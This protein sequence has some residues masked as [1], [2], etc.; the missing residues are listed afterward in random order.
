MRKDVDYPLRKEMV[1][2]AKKNLEKAHKNNPNY[3][4]YPQDI[5]CELNRT[6]NN[7]YTFDE[8]G[9]VHSTLKQVKEI[10]GVK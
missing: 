1:L 7:R 9:N 8:Y 5:V 4:V 3:R 10:L 2:R 6:L